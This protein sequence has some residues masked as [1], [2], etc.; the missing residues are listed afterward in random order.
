MVDY[1]KKFIEKLEETNR[2]FPN[3]EMITYIKENGLI[4]TISTEKMMILCR[5][6]VKLVKNAGIEAGDRVA[7]IAPITANTVITCLGLGI[8]QITNLMIDPNLSEEEI[9]SLIKEADVRGVFTTN[10]IYC[11]IPDE[12]KE[13]IPCFRLDVPTGN[14]DIF[15]TSVSKVR[16]QPTEDK[17][18]TVMIMLYSSGT[19]SSTKAVL[20]TYHS[21]LQSV[22]ICAEIYGVTSNKKYLQIFPLNHISGYMSMMLFLLNECCVGLVENV[23]SSK[24]QKALQIYQPHYFAMVPKVY[25]VM[26]DK[27]YAAIAEKGKLIETLVKKALSLSGFMRKTTGSC[28]G[29]YIFKPIY[30]KVFGENIIGLCTM[31]TAC[32]KRTAELFLNMGLVWAN[33]YATT[34]TNG[35]TTSTGIKDKYPVNSVGNIYRYPNIQV[36]IQNPDENGI[37]EIQVKTS[38]IMKGYFR[39]PELTSQA[40]EDGYFKT[41]D[42]GYV[43]DKGYLY[44]TGRLKETI[45]LPN[46]EKM[47]P[48]E[49]DAMYQKICPNGCMFASC[50]VPINGKDYDEIHLFVEL[51]ANQKENI[52]HIKECLFEESRKLGVNY[53]IKDVHF[54]DKIPVTAVGKVRRFM[55]K[56]MVTEECDTSKKEIDILIDENC[57]VQIDV[58][59][60]IL[61][62][63]K[64]HLNSNIVISKYS[65]LK[66][67]LNLDSL[68]MFEIS[69][70]IE[71]KYKISI[72]EHLHEV[73]TVQDIVDYILNKDTKI[74]KKNE[75]NG[76]QINEFPKRKTFFH[77]MTFRVLGTF[78]KLI[79]PICV[80][81]LENL[82][83]DKNYIL[84][85]NHESHLDGFWV[86]L[87]MGKHRPPLERI[88]C[89]AKEEHLENV[90]SKFFLTMLGGI[91]VDRAGNPTPAMR[92]TKQCLKEG[93]F[94]LIHP[95]GT[96]TRTGQ[97]NV[98]KQGAADLA[99]KANVPLIPVKIQ[100]AYEI[101]PSKRAV[102]R[103]F[104]GKNWKRYNLDISFG[105]PLYAEED[106]C[107]SLTKKLEQQ[108]MDLGK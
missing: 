45:I 15:E 25:D 21:I 82:P 95:E 8:G 78:S 106:S 53:K 64:K 43:D 74:R 57:D 32:S 94:V 35:P 42:Y 16:K 76:Y 24:L 59:D 13:E 12:I 40:F 68:L 105:K 102:P 29:K 22:R 72:S 10:H 84:C 28:I 20:I 79:W 70:S 48:M 54:C 47:A 65:D 69:T 90:G 5:N 3:Q 37:G 46:G 75:T 33:T 92:R 97:M 61:N 11:G 67:D 104:D 4:E 66:Q 77:R 103:V 9:H 58:A 34:E 19:T 91:P 30:K 107:Q 6:F 101:Y 85:P 93:Y 60:E 81:G 80:N 96:R 49:V 98:L 2:K 89:M 39:E 1:H 63:I 62:I 26:A 71:E 23:N 56:K 14:I 18:L 27:I 17:D 83:Q 100:G 73:H 88:V 86:W 55:L 87:A 41:G 50:A 38:L 36:R 52:E 108:L 31:G 44:V 7:V 51:S 99:I